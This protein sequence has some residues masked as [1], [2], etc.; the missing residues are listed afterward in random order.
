MS[1]GFK[2]RLEEMRKLSRLESVG[3]A[4]ACGETQASLLERLQ[5]GA[6]QHTEDV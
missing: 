1:K 3:Q 5:A 6:C 4:G 2:R